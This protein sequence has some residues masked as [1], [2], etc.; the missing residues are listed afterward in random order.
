[1]NVFFNELFR[2]VCGIKLSFEHDSARKNLFLGAS[3]CWVSV[4]SLRKMDQ[5]FLFIGTFA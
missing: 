1:M 3:F 4:F 2:I 5:K